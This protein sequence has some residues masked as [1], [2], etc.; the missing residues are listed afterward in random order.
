MPTINHAED[1][2][3]AI[4]W[5]RE[6]LGNDRSLIV[7]LET[8]ALK[9]AEIVQIGAIN[10]DGSTCLDRL[11]RPLG[12]ISEGAA[13][14]HGIT[15]NAL[16][17]CPTFA[18]QTTTITDALDMRHIVIFNLR[19]DYEVLYFELAR[20][21]G[22]FD[23]REWMGKSASWKCAMLQY[24]AFVGEPGKYG[25]YKWQRLPGGDHSALGDCRAC[26]KI[27]HEMATASV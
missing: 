11:I 2:A 8:T 6:V 21:I 5:A 12:E 20:A 16:K 23:A 17:D 14:I 27:I 18:E 15:K 3:R 4:L 22:E 10:M 1:R 26:M 24:S 25:G 19:F 7:D 9:D 13:A